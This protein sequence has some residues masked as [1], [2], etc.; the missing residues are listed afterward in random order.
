V[1]TYKINDKGKAVQRYHLITQGLAIGSILFLLIPSIVPSYGLNAGEKTSQITSEGKILYVGGIGE[2]NYSKIQ[3]AIADSTDGDTVYVYDDSAPYFEHVVIDK[4]ITLFGENKTTTV[5]NGSLLDTSVDTLCVIRDD[6]TIRGFRITNNQGYYYQAAVKIKGNDTLLSNCII[7]ENEWIGVY[8]IDVSFCRL[9]ECEL[10][11]NLVAIHLVNSRNNILRNCVCHDNAD[12]ITLYQSSDDNQLI[13]CIC[14]R[15]HFD[16][17]LIQQSSGNHLMGCVCQNGYDGISLP[18]AP[19]TTMRNNSLLNNYANFGIG[20]SSVSDFYCDIDTSN[21]INGKPMYYLIEQN[22]RMFD[23]TTELGF[24][25][26]VNCQNISVKHCNFSHN[27]EGILLAGTTDA[28]IENCSFR[29][30]DGHGMYLISCQNITIKTCVFQD[31]FWDGI[32]L[33]DSSNNSIQ[34]CSY[35]G[36][37]AGLNLDMSTHNTLQGLTIDHCSVGISLDS[38]EDNVLKDNEMFLCGL[39]VSGN[40]PAEYRNDVDSSN[41]VNGKPVYYYLNETNKTIPLDAGQVILTRCTGCT[42]SECHL[43]D[44]SIGIE[45]AYSTMNII[46]DNVLTNNSIVAID[47]DGSDNENNIIRDNLI[48]GNNYGIDV[49]SSNMNIFQDNV[50]IQNGMGFSFDACWKNTIIGNIIQDGSCGI[51]LVSS[52]DNTLTGNS[53]RNTSVFGLYFLSSC[54]NVLDFNAMINCSIMVYGYDADEFRNDVD[55]TNTVNGKPVYYLFGQHRITVPQDAG[56]VIL[57]DSEHCTIKGLDLNKGTI[58]IILAYSSN[59]IIQGNI[60]KNQ[61]MTAIDLG[62]AHNDYTTI[63]GNIIQENSYG[64]D[65]EYSKNNIIRKNRIVPN[66]YGIFLGNTLN[67]IIWRN[68][69]TKNTYGVIATKANV[70]KIFLNNF[71]QNYAYGLSVEACAVTARWNW[72]GAITGPDA[73]G[74]GDHLHVAENGQITYAP[75]LRLPVLF[76]GMLRFLFMTEHQNPTNATSRSPSQA[77]FV[78]QK[79]NSNHFDWFGLEIMHDEKEYVPPKTAIN[80]YFDS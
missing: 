38:S 64:I 39:Q 69:L 47:L 48:Q 49:D 61:S 65:L 26:L 60:I 1:E 44:A 13:D 15:N 66:G 41:T 35:Y 59:N 79:T 17:I 28:V 18:Y 37:V 42:V 34:N 21:T 4:S 5:I 14:S 67:T 23:E 24:L 55:S 36:S 30:N 27:F 53:I 12:A 8:L 25:G 62:S 75:W 46:Q 33:F 56:E 19:D 32:F 58:G 72:W 7:D 54:R 20:S 9:E 51:Y 52:S 45:L 11:D 63:S 57:I 2:G 3:D 71:C 74:N 10:F 43:S 31:S 76:T 70:S 80:Q 78:P 68:T 22:N 6:V 40:T 77:N 73:D 50:M 16:G 29:H